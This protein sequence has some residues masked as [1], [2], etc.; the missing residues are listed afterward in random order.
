[1]PGDEQPTTEELL[2]VQEDKV[3]TEEAR[4][5]AAALETEEHQ[6]ER[7]ADKAA[8]LRDK[9]AEQRAADAGDR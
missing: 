4:R 9:L 6:A 7:R 3:H 5:E 1:M 2:A 8:Y